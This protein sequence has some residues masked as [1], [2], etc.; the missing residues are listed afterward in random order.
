M[1]EFIGKLNARESGRG[2]V[3]RLPT[4]A[5]WGYAARAGTTGARYGAVDR[6]AWYSANSNSSILGWN[7]PR[8]VG[9]KLANAWGLHDM[10]GNVSEWTADWYGPYTSG[11]VTDPGGPSAGSFRVGRGSA[12]NHVGHLFIRAASR[13]YAA[14]DSRHEG[15]GFRLVRTMPAWTNT[16]GMEFVWMRTGRFRMGSPDGE[17]G[18]RKDEIQHPVQFSAGY[19]LGKYEVTRAEWRQVM[20]SV[21]PAPPHCRKDCPVASVSWEDAQEFIRKLH[22][23][24]SR[25]GTRYRLPTEA[26]WEYAARAGTTGARYGALDAIAWY[27]GNSGGK[28]SVPGWCGNSDCFVRS[29]PH[30]AW[31]TADP[32]FTHV[33][34]HTG[35]RSGTAMPILLS[36]QPLRHR[37]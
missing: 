34:W 21:P 16:L 3:Y 24:E 30:C 22:G 7:G 19:W 14:P 17:K 37:C 20:G 4:E 36:R 26:E 18:R 32:F 23:R 6:I 8:R 25:L 35:M 13:G 2:Y 10:H 33:R 15:L 31:H 1:Q 29:G 28:L 9:T 5:E 27:A 11:P 12:W